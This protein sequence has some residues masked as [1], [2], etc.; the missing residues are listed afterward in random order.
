MVGVVPNV[1]KKPWTLVDDPSKERAARKRKAEVGT[2]TPL[3]GGMGI[4]RQR[5][6]GSDPPG[7]HGGGGIALTHLVGVTPPPKQ[8]A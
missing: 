3:K 2:L 4:P 1:R 8:H 7:G 6:G 5:G